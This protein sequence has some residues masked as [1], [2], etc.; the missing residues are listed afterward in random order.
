M[1]VVSSLNFYLM[2]NVAVPIAQDFLIV[3]VGKKIDEKTMTNGQFFIKFVIFLSLLYSITIG[4][5]SVFRIAY[6]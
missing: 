5:K 6:C 1:K 2:N 3:H 4:I